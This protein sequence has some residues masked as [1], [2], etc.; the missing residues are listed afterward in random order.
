MK[1]DAN[2]TTSATDFA[3]A[4][5]LWET[6]EGE[7]PV[8]ATAIHNGHGVR[9]DVDCHLRI[10]DAERL[11]EEDPFTGCAIGGVPNRI[12]VNQSRF[13]F[14][15]NRSAA[16]AV[17]LEPAD[18]WGLDLYESPLPAEAVNESRSRHQRY[19]RM[20][21]GF[22]QRLTA[23]HR[24]IVLIDVHSYNHRRDGPDAPPA[25]REEAP[26]I[27]IGTH[28]MPVD[29]WT[30]VLDAFIASLRNFEFRGRRLDVRKNVAF[31]GKG[32]Q[33]RFAHA[34]FP[35]QV[36]AIAFEFKKFYM[37]EWSGQPDLADL[38]AMRDLIAATLPDLEAVLQ[39]M[40]RQS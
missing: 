23:R 1:L 18:A 19:Y 40:D 15:L 35:M 36:C 30:P 29:F 25:N 34:Q 33:T 32:E 6:A 12:V 5:S 37:D 16:E 24:H 22:L 31:Q 21:R 2:S 3:R 39:R 13:E 26:E 28:S 4:P 17:Y 38:A 7:G 11:R 10:S 14:D 27:N 20:L 9:P 8:L